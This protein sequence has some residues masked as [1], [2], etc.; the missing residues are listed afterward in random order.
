MTLNMMFRD[1]HNFDCYKVSAKLLAAKQGRDPGTVTNHVGEFLVSFYDMG[2]H[3]VVGRLTDDSVANFCEEGPVPGHHH[4]KAIQAVRP[5]TGAVAS[6]RVE[7]YD[8]RV[9]AWSLSG[10][11]FKVRPLCPSFLKHA[12]FIRVT[13]LASW[14]SL[15]MSDSHILPL[16]MPITS[17]PSQHS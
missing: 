12:N 15:L 1:Q 14:L 16:P 6:Y 11:I 9:N 5:I 4:I 17:K 8:S 3:I 7:W 2:H 13:A 10:A